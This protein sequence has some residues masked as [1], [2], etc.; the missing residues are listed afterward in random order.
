M[1]EI[2]MNCIQ[3]C[4][5]SEVLFNRYSLLN[6][7]AVCGDESAYGEVNILWKDFVD[8]FGIFI[9]LLNLGLF[10]PQVKFQFCNKNFWYLEVLR[11]IYIAQK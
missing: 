2:I 4:L 5:N 1:P 9:K 8:L 6:F 10:K 3:F 11:K 7:L